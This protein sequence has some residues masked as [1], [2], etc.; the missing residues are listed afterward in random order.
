MPMSAINLFSPD[1]IAD[2][3]EISGMLLEASKYP[4]SHYISQIKHG[5]ELNNSLPIILIVDDL[6]DNLFSLNAVLK[7][8]GYIIHLANS[9]ALAIEMALKQHYDCIVLDVQMPKMDGFEVVNILSQNDFT[10]NIPII[11]LSSLGSDKEKV[12]R[13]MDSGA[14]DF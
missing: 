8:E 14:I 12:L 1:V 4:I 5:D 7:F 2:I 13:G 6:E 11:F 3:P 9:G 10:K